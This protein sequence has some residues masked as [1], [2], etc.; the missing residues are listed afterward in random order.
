MRAMGFAL[1]GMALAVGGLL[2]IG[3]SDVAFAKSPKHAVQQAS[4]KTCKGKNEAYENGKCIVTSNEN[5]DHVPLDATT[6]P[7]YRS[8][9]TAHHHKKAKH[10]APA[11]AA[12][13]EPDA[14][15]PNPGSNAPTRRA[16]ARD[17]VS[18]PGRGNPDR[19]PQNATTEPF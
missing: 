2:T 4:P 9:A 7:F 14:N 11:A 1:T 16:V 15:A 17:R 12:A 10:A 18:N 8:N 6:T 19:T 13:S 3:V 5:P